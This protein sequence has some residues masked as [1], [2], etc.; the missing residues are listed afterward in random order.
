MNSFLEEALFLATK[1]IAVFPVH[2]IERGYCACGDRTCSNVG[3]HPRIKNWVNMASVSPDTIR[4]WWGK[5][6]N[7]NIGI[8]TGSKSKVDVLD[9]DP[10]HGGVESLQ[11]LEKEFGSLPLSVRSIT[12]GGGFHIYFSRLE[13]IKRISNSVGKLGRG[14]DVRGDGGFVVAP[15]SLHKSGQSYTWCEGQSLREKAPEPLPSWL[16]EKLTSKLKKVPGTQSLSSQQFPEGERNNTLTSLAGTMRNRNLAKESI[17]AALLNE[18]AEKC[19]PPLD[20][21][22]VLKIVESIF[23]YQPNHTEFGGFPLTDYGNAQRLIKEHGIDLHYSPH[24]KKWIEWADTHW[25][26]DENEGIV[27]RAKH[28]IRKLHA[29]ASVIPDE[30]LRITTES[31]ARKSESEERLRKMT[32]L[33]KSEPHV[34]I[35]MEEVDS[36]PFLLNLTNGTLNLH[37]FRLQPHCREDLLTKITPIEFHP[38]ATCPIWQMFLNRIFEGNEEIINF[39]Q[40]AVGYSLTGDISEQCVFILFGNGANGKSTFLEV[41]GTLLGPYSAQASFTSFLAND[42]E[43]VRNDLA[44]LRG[45]RL[46]RAAEV[47][48]GR[49]LSEVVIKQVSGGDKITARFLY[50]EFF[51]FHP[52]FK[53]FLACNH[54]PFIKGNDNAIWRRIRLIPFSVTIPKEDQDKNLLNKL[55]QELPGI[56]AWAI[57]GCAEWRTKGLQAPPEIVSASESYRFEMDVLA[58]FLDECCVVD[59]NFNVIS[60][61]LYDKYKSWAEENGEYVFTHNALSRRLKER[62]FYPAKNG[63]NRIWKGLRLLNQGENT[64][65]EYE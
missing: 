50:G 3:K 41:L 28:T 23:R 32:L 18:N 29:Q 33:A 24:R 52:Q 40:R 47:E 34:P 37:T 25:N 7:D 60:G 27:L 45:M 53:L 38:E 44:R 54:L 14:L 36:N 49:H 58:K 43:R 1:G 10:R 20:K 61:K 51:E 55:Q 12:G 21:E 17:V 9:V 56:L 26:W 65:M 2:T 5:W 62:G 59:R 13:H 57:R 6:P 63:G 35:L 22:E 42:T 30:K 8:A 16:A 4:T 64:R 11:I 39:V 46:V 31:W 15:P 48:E 19:N